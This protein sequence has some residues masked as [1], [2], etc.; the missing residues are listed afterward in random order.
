MKKIIAILKDTG[1]G[2]QIFIL[3]NDLKTIDIKEKHQKKPYFFGSLEYF[4]K[5]IKNK[6]DTKNILF[7]NTEVL[8]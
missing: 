3:C 4:K 7:Y 8:K 6:I 2:Q 1:R 5:Y